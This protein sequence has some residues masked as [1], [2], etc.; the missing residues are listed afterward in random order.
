M[1]CAP[2][3]HAFPIIEK[4]NEKYKNNIQIISLN[5]KDKTDERIKKMD[6]FISF[7][8][9]NTDI[10]FIADSV[11]EKYKVYAYPAF[12]IIDKNGKIIYN[13]VGVS[14]TLFED[15]SKIIEKIIFL[16]KN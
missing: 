6:Q 4:L 3:I 5:N 14:E 11:I 2:C 16:R 9:I 8:P 12:Y 15:M 10:L 7:N 13:Q 1:N